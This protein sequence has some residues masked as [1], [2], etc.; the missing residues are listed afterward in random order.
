[1]E[2]SLKIRFS[3]ESGYVFNVGGKYEC[4]IRVPNIFSFSNSE[5][6]IFRSEYVLK[7]LHPL[8]ALLCVG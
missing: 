7:C 8:Y 6:G 5:I 2:S 4:F 1:M 3:F